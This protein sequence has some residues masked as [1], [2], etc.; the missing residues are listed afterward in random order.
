MSLSSCVIVPVI[1]ETQEPDNVKERRE[2]ESEEE[3]AMSEMSALMN[4]LEEIKKQNDRQAAEMKQL[5]VETRAN[6]RGTV[7]DLEEKLKHH[8]DEAAANMKQHQAEAVAVLKNGQELVMS[9]L[10][11][12]RQAV[13]QVLENQD[14][15]AHLTELTY[16]E[17]HNRT[18]QSKE[19]LTTV[20]YEVHR[21]AKRAF[22]N[23]PIETQEYVVARQF[24]EGIADVDVQRIVRL[25]SPRTLQ[26]ILVKA[27]KIEAATKATQLTKHLWDKIKRRI[28][29]RQNIPGN[30]DQLIQAA[31][32]EWGNVPQE[33]TNSLID[34][35]PRR[36]RA[37]INDR[38]GNTDY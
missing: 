11:N 23:S 22:A 28:R 29:A 27:L 9:R 15:H 30:T 31:L 16:E 10:E 12:Q 20:A 24:L 6:M 4:M 26:D 35:M 2:E 33:E 38:G 13:S 34:S 19:D 36:I 14:K 32:E 8:Q 3:R 7:E 1:L 37:C 18:Q 25:S 17:L 5:A 21:V